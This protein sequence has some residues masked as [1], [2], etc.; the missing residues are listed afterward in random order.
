M[1]H[2]VL[3]V[4]NVNISTQLPLVSLDVLINEP[5]MIVERKMVQRQRRAATMVLVKWTNEPTEEA[6]WELLYEL[7][8]KYPN[9]KP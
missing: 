9:F 5:E 2:P 3:P 6:M 1:I 8:K 4:G 7:Q